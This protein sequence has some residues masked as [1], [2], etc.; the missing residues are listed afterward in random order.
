MFSFSLSHL[1]NKAIIKLTGDLD[2]D[3]TKIVEGE[4]IPVLEKYELVDLNFHNVPFVD[5]TGM[6]LLLNLVQTFND[7]GTKV[8][9]SNVKE[10]VMDVFDLLQIPEILGNGVFV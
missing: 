1:N 7:K 9:I 8:T 10:E 4:L 2:I 6:G 5:S 3:G